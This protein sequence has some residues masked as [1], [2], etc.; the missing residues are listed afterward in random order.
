LKTRPIFFFFFY[1]RIM[2]EQGAVEEARRLLS[3]A[4]EKIALAF[5]ALE[6]TE[7]EL[8]GADEQAA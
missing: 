6:M 1:E 7:T 8:D 4:V 2:M 5:L 3:E